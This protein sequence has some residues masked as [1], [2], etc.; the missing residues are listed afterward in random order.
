MPS[1]G[2]EDTAAPRDAAAGTAGARRPLTSRSSHPGAR[3]ISGVQHWVPLCGGVNW[4][5]FSQTAPNGQ[6]T[7]KRHWTQFTCVGR[8]GWGPSCPLGVSVPSRPGGSPAGSPKQP[9]P[10]SGHGGGQSSTPAPAWVVT[11]SQA[12]PRTWP[13]GWFVPLPAWGS[14]AGGSRAGR[15]CVSW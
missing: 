4:G 8:A 9:G 5:W 13:R 6:E 10:S 11:L 7:R 3:P 14:G 2:G 1:T 15:P 12:W